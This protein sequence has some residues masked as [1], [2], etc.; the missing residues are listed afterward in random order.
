MGRDRCWEGKLKPRATALVSWLLN[1]G[2]VRRRAGTSVLINQLAQLL[3]N[4][5]AVVSNKVN[6]H[7]FAFAIDGATRPPIAPPILCPLMRYG[8]PV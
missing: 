3:I 7:T 6:T 1:T 5:G 2:G 8:V 4:R